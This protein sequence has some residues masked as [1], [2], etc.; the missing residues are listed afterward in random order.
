M[1]NK[2][3]LGTVQ[4]GL[5]YGINNSNGKVKLDEVFDML[6]EAFKRNVRVLDSAKAYGDAHSVIGLYHKNRPNNKFQIITKLP[7]EFN[8]A[9]VEKEILEYCKELN[10][11]RLNTLMFH[12]YDSY[13]KNETIISTLFNLKAIGLIEKLGVS[14]YDNVQANNVIKDKGIDLIQLPFNLLDNRFLR[15]DILKYAKKEGKEVH[16]RSA[17]LQGLFFMDRNSSIKHF[18]S[19][20]YQIGELD[21]IS[22]NFNIPIQKLALAYCIN[23]PEID[24]VLIGV[25]GLNQLK[26]NLDLIDYPNLEQAFFE[27]DKIKIENENLLNPSKWN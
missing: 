1:I 25:D 2:L 19:L 8:S 5:D 12:S 17:F 11:E 7:H 18:K 14:V 9:E 13:K 26:S 22:E 4:F 3:V 21:K 24:K 20:K 10:V 27:I 23:Q 16:S 15:S 6:D